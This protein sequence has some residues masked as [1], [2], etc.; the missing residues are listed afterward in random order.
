MQPSG[1]VFKFADP[2]QYAAAVRGADL[3]VTP[4]VPGPFRTELTRFGLARFGFAHQI[5]VSRFSE[6]SPLIKRSGL[7]SWIAAIGFLTEPNQPAMRIGGLDLSSDDIVVY[8]SG[9]SMH[10]RTSA[11]CRF[12]SVTLFPD[13]LAATA[14][15]FTGREI[16]VPADT[17]S[18]RPN[19]RHLARLRRVHS[20]AGRLAA[21]VPRADSHP[22][23]ANALEEALRHA[24][25]MCMTDG[26]RFDIGRQGH[27]HLLILSKLEE[28]L[29]TNFDRALYLSEICAAT[30]ASENTVRI[31]C[32]ENLGMGPV[33]Y[34]WL[35]RMHL[36]RRALL[37]N[38]G[39]GTVTSIAMAHGFWELG[40]FSVAYR[41]LFGETPLATLRRPAEDAPA[42][43]NSR[44]L[45][46]FA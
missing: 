28:F 15:A 23:A 3:T 21:T 13:D 5:W 17:Y 22:E 10:H 35:R 43:R 16:S 19:P 42:S 39:G 2:D 46:A 34:L 11:A 32:N 9:T 18:I 36:A 37:A 33:R 4:M 38:E 24:M 29:A 6:S 7:Y 44:P 25:I 40:R 14:R 45:S 12:G 27:H 31:C 8:G 30:N 26:E 1:S 41:G 20:V